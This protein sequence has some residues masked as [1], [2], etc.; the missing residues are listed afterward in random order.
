LG[1]EGVYFYLFL[2]FKSVSVRNVSVI[3]SGLIILIKEYLSIKIRSYNIIKVIK[4]VCLEHIID[5]PNKLF[6]YY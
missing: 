4:I 5:N 6:P 3:L 2:S 1:G